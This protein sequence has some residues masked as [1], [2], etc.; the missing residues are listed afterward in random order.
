MPAGDWLFMLAT[1]LVLVLV[2]GFL[3]GLVT[4]FFLG[5]LWR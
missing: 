5:Y 2:G 4:G 3:A 1:A